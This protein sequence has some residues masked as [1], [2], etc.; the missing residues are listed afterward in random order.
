MLASTVVKTYSYYLTHT[1]WHKHKFHSYCSIYI[2]YYNAARLSRR[3]RRN[4]MVDI[5]LLLLLPRPLI[6]PFVRSHSTFLHSSEK[7]WN[8]WKNR[9]N[10][11]RHYIVVYYIVLRKAYCYI[12][13]HAHAVHADWKNNET[14]ALDF[15]KSPTNTARTIQF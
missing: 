4:N 6:A 8:E 7:T 14:N 1:R 3:N 2:W 13:T 11:Y 10:D 12:E 9:I 5:N 15:N